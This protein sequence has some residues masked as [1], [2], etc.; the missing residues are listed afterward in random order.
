MVLPEKGLSCVGPGA[1]D[2]PGTLPP[3]LHRYS[4]GCVVVQAEPTERE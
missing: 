4:S 3:A 1:P 2:A